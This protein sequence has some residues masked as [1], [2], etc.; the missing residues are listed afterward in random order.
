MIIALH[1][2]DQF[3]GWLRAISPS[4]VSRIW[5]SSSHLSQSLEI[6]LS[7][8]SISPQESLPVRRVSCWESRMVWGSVDL[9]VWAETGK[10]RC[11]N[12]RVWPREV[13][14]NQKGIPIVT[15]EAV[16]NNSTESSGIPPFYIVRITN[17]DFHLGPCAEVVSPKRNSAPW[18]HDHVL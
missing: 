11:R 3:R 8:F 1:A 15:V 2:G 4:H 9:G 17:A 5:P 16:E 10:K 6:S 12:L 13:S 14:Q 18:V 7:S